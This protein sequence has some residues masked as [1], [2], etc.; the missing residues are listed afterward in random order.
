MPLLISA[1]ILSARPQMTGE[2]DPRLW[3]PRVAKGR[4]FFILLG[5]LVMIF[6]LLAF[7]AARQQP[8]YRPSP[9]E[10]QQVR[11]SSLWSEHGTSMDH[12]AAKG[13][14]KVELLQQA[15]DLLARLQRAGMDPHDEN[16]VSLKSWVPSAEAMATGHGSPVA[17][18]G[19]VRGR[20]P[21]REGPSEHGGQLS[22]SAASQIL[23]VMPNLHGV[24]YDLPRGAKAYYLNLDRAEGRR[25]A[26]ERAFRGIWGESL[27]RVPG[28]L[29]SDKEWVRTYWSHPALC[30]IRIGDQK[31]MGD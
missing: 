28:R 1:L 8:A 17:K 11:P 6:C 21:S 4:T 10:A 7:E 9:L 5:S 31:R 2:L 26:M 18:E 14:D 22:R 30:M 13:E 23:D 15:Q 29:G 27:H 25:A 16:M 12:A 20:E 19:G 3:R 24:S